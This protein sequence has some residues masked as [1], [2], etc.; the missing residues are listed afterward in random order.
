MENFIWPNEYWDVVENGVGKEHKEKKGEHA[1]R[2]LMD[3]KV[4]NYLF[5]SIDRKVLQT[6][7]CKESSKGI[8]DLMN[9]K[10]LGSMVKWSQMHALWWKFKLLHMMDEEKVITYC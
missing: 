9:V 10:Y 7:V 8:W 2:K 5:Q 1:T 3:L 4:K 6:I